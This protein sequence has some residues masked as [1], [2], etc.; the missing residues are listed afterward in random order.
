MK[1]FTRYRTIEFLELL[2]GS[3]LPIIFWVSLVFGFDAP[4]IAILTLICAVIHEGGHIAAISILTKSS[5][6]LRGHS[7]GFRISVGKSM[8][9]GEEIAV[10]LSGP[11]VNVAVFLI[12]LPFFDMMDG[13][14]GVFG[15]LNLATGVSNLLPID[16]YDGYRAICTYFL[17][18]NKHRAIFFLEITSFIVSIL[19]TFVALYLIDR[20]S[21]GYWIF[22]LFF[23]ASMSKILNFAKSTNLRE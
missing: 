18:R 20:L 16:G 19:T 1:Y 22:G 9:Y 14:L 2:S 8:S 5:M 10:L 7:S 13:Y 6:K 15:C 12:T 21:E 17:S 4:Y 11:A 23:F 3:V